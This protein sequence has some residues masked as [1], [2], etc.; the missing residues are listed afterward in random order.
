MEYPTTLELKWLY[1]KEDNQLPYDTFA[2]IDENGFI[3]ARNIQEEEV[4]VSI[5]HQHNVSRRA[6][7]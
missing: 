6:N 2:I 3:I 4:A 5:I 7:I 1:L